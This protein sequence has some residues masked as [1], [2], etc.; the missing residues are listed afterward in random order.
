MVQASTDAIVQEV[1]YPHPIDLVW[2]AL[3]DR[4]AIAEWAFVEGAV[5]EGFRPEVGARYS[6][7][8]PDPEGWSGRVEGEILAVEPPHRLSYTWVGDGGSTVV[9]FILASTAHG[10]RLRLEQ[11]GF[12]RYGEKGQRARESMDEGWGRHILRGSFQRVLDKLALKDQ[13][14]T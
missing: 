1:E 3:T 13:P 6:F 2:E 4:D 5:V 11:T 7:V 9:T 10:T 8:D 12:D 14:R